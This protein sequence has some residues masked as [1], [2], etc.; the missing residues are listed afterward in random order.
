[1]SETP[2]V[3]APVNPAAT[4]SRVTPTVTRVVS[5]VVAVGSGAVLGL[6]AWLDPSPLGHSTHTQLG[7]HPCT[8][9]SL[10]GLPCPMC[11]ATTT[12][13]MMADGRVF[14]ALLNQP[15]A[16]LLFAITLV[17]FAI[18]MA[19]TLQP[20]RRWQRVADRLGPREGTLA[21]IFLVLM[22]LGWVYK[23]AQMSYFSQ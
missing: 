4:P 21:T 18:S 8:F 7:L 3:D 12:F 11:G 1:M 2:T 13:A 16:A 23:I 20:R 9:L 17:V 19:E 15:F 5:A 10:T 14:S 6:A 22:G